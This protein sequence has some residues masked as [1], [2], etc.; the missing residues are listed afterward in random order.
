MRQH[1][2]VR[3]ARGFTLIELLVAI[4][5]MALLSLVS[6][7]GLESMSRATTHNQQRADAVLTLQA[8]LAQ[9]GADLDAVTT[10]AQTRPVDW[11]GRVLRL[12][13]RGSDDTAPSVQVVA[14]TLKSGPDGVRWRRWQSLP[15]T[16][17]GEWQQA[18]NLAAAWAQ[19]GGVGSN[20]GYSDVAL[21]PAN[22]WQIFFFRDNSWVP[23]SQLP[24]TQ[25]NP[26]N[27]S[28]P[29]VAMPDGVRLVI[30]LPPGDGLSGTL[31]RDW[32]KPTV[33]APKTS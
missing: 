16:T 10:L 19:D 15:F 25:P 33:G 5:V 30:T 31:T 13:R 27:P 4:A 21:V 11:D 6:W 1:A 32:V 20:G 2:G 7:R 29:I 24:T 12:T 17:R 9:W 8:T 3:A 26:N 18:W 28:G 22:S 23:A 14:W